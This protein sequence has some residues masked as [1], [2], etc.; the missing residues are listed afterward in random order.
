MVIDLAEMV[1]M[2]INPI[3]ADENGL[4]ALDANILIEL[5]TGSATER[6]AISLSQTHGTAVHLAG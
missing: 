4:L 2:D 1:E 6:L 3:W 5:A